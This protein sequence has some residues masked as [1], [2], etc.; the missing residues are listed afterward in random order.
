[1]NKHCLGYL[2]VYVTNKATFLMDNHR[3]D[4]KL[5]NERVQNTLAIIQAKLYE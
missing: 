1:M 5:T 2:G 3:A 4:S